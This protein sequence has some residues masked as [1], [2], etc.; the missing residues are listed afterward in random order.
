MTPPDPRLEAGHM[1]RVGT[2]YPYAFG[3][4]P[5]ECP[6]FF[7][8]ETL[9]Q[10]QFARPEAIFR[11]AAT[12]VDSAHLDQRA[13]RFVNLLRAERSEARSETHRSTVDKLETVN[14]ESLDIDGADAFPAPVHTSPHADVTVGGHGVRG[15]GR[16][17]PFR[18]RG[19]SPCWSRTRGSLTVITFSQVNGGYPAKARRTL[20]VR[21]RQ[22]SSA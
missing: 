2:P 18:R 17:V 20:R 19:S 12:L 14:A 11:K 16:R 8:P 5:E 21:C 10:F 9:Y 3:A 22:T 7:D 15:A 6:A 4:R 1:R 13:A